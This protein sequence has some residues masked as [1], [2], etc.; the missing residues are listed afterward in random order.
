MNK[1]FSLNRKDL[2]TLNLANVKID[3]ESGNPY[4]NAGT[5][6][7]GF[8]LPGVSILMGKS[9]LKGMN[10]EAKNALANRVKITNAR[11][12]GI[13]QDESTGE[14]IVVLANDGRIID[15][16]TLPPPDPVEGNSPDTGPET[17]GERGKPYE[18]AFDQSDE[19]LRD[20]ILDAARNLNLGEEQVIAAVE[21][22]I[23]RE[24]T[25]AEKFQLGEEITRQ[26]IED[27]VQYL[28]SNST[29][30]NT[31]GIVRIRTPRGYLRRTFAG[32]DKVQAEK[33][34]NRLK[35]MGLDDETIDNKII[36]GMSKK[37]KK[38]L[39]YVKEEQ[40]NEG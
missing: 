30:E 4:R 36:S 23:G 31:D 20:A 16:F 17:Q 19:I 1:V 39:G 8:E 28:Y 13:R 18:A 29:D 35:A 7:F 15:S 32:L 27:L 22:R 6:K 26:R 12:M 25:D 40:K 3:V 2:N 11:Q 34:L 24:L 37:L 10:T 21:A 5:G 14:L 38:E 33:V 9:F